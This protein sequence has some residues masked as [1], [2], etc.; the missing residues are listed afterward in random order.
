MKEEIKNYR[1]RQLFGDFFLARE[2]ERWGGISRGMCSQE[3]AFNHKTNDGML[4]AS[5]TNLTEQEGEMQERGGCPQR[6]L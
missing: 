1:H 4:N 3:R 2:A 6:I 5:R